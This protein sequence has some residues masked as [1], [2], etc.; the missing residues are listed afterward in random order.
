MCRS[1]VKVSPAEYKKIR[2]SLPNVSKQQKETRKLFDLPEIDRV[3]LEELVDLLE[4]FEWVTNELQGNMVTISKVYPCIELF[5]KELND[6]EKVPKYTIELRKALS[7]SLDEKFGVIIKN[8]T[9]VISSFLGIFLN[10]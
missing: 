2:N 8:E 7:K 5:F 1:V 9:F 10:L 6:P 3:K 4:A